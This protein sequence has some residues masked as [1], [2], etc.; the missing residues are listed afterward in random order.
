M[1]EQT[2]SPQQEMEAQLRSLQQDLIP[3]GT[4]SVVNRSGEFRRALAVRRLGD[5]RDARVP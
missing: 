2:L 4:A 1:Y 5:A 3:I